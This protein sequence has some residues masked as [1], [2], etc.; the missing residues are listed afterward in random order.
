ME[1]RT[2]AWRPPEPVSSLAA[3]QKTRTLRYDDPRVVHVINNGRPDAYRGR[4][5]P[6]T[7]VDVDG[8]EPTNNDA[9]RALR[10]AAIWRKL[11]FGAPSES[12]NRFV[13]TML[14]AIETSTGTPPE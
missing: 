5:N 12:G 11:S 14:T 13:E 2:R 4:A 7:F 6:W 9:E 3:I 10:H 1:S 8:V